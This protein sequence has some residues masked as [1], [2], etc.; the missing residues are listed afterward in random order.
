MKWKEQKPK[1]SM[2]VSIY[3]SHNIFNTGFG[4]ISTEINHQNN[5]SAIYMDPALTASDLSALN[6]TECGVI[7]F[8]AF[9]V[10]LKAQALETEVF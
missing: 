7:A 8:H 5:Y 4:V 10:H 3:F 2:S 9:I 1:L 6:C